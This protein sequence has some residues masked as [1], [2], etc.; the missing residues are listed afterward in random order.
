MGVG[1]LLVPA[2]VLVVQEQGV[3]VVAPPGGSEVGLAVCSLVAV[4]C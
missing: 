2:L 1:P 4:R 3:A